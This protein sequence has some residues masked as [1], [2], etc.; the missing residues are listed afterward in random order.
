MHAFFWEFLVLEILGTEL[1]VQAW[2]RATAWKLRNAP[3]A[4]PDPDGEVYLRLRLV[5]A[6]KEISSFSFVAGIK[7]LWLLVRKCVWLSFPG[8]STSK[9]EFE[10]RRAC[11]STQY[12]LWPWASLT[13]KEEKHT[14]DHR[15]C[16]LMAGRQSYAQLACVCNSGTHASH[17]GRG[18]PKSINKEGNL[19]RA[20]P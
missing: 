8:Q 12:Y 3:S 1:W 13:P 2:G 6:V 17:S 5:F 11:T 15:R 18:P 10:G 4:L 16:E 19:L 7:T 20:C 14:V 9:Q